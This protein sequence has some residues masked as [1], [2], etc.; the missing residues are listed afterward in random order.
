MPRDRKFK[1]RAFLKTTGVTGV[2]TTLPLSGTAAADDDTIID[3]GFDLTLD[4]LRE[5]LVVFDSRDDVD[6]LADLDLVNGYYEF[7]VLP[8]GYTELY[9]DQIRDIASWDSVRFVR[10][11]VELDYY[12]DDGREVTGVSK[13]QSDF[14]YEGDGVHTAV[15]D[16]GVDGDHPDLQDQ[17]VNNFQ[18]VG[19]PLGSPT[20]WADAGIADTDGGG[21]GTHCSGTIAGDGSASDGQ[22]RGMAPNAD[23]TVYAGG[24]VLVVL[25]TAAAYDHIL[26]RVRDG[27]TDVKIVSNSYGSSN[28][29][30]F[31]PD[32]ALNTATWKAYQE[33]LLSVFA[34]GNSGPGTNTLNQYAKAPQ[35]LGVAA[36]NDQKEVTNFSSRGR[37]QDSTNTPDN[38]NRQT[39][40]DNL[41]SYYETGSASGPLGV[42]RPGIGAPGNAIVSTMSPDDA[43]QSQSPDD[44]R[45]YYATISG[46]SMACPMT[47]GIATLVVDAYRQN[48]SGDI[49]PLELLNA[50]NAESDEVYDSYTPYNVGSGFVDADAAV[51]RVENGNLASFGDVTLVN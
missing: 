5:A 43:L 32:N 29:S 39:A 20:L 42:Y 18:W 14:G 40:L 38:W 11:N 51:T 50:I 33:G 2:A 37:K 19:N 49:G 35:V 27:S 25:K 47:A 1:R 13:V 7:D 21:H 48:N 4:V 44:G 17:L 23:L 3:D 12:N 24:A 6:R 15:I 34:A 31:N 46:T 41:A 9:A 30:A 26:K 16:S 36:T 45:L 8:I 28:G 10:K 22:F